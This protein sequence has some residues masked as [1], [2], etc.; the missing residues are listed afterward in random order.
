MINLRRGSRATPVKLLQRLL[1][2]KGTLTRLA[3]DGIFGPRTHAAVLLFQRRERLAPDGIVGPRT[4]RR[5]G[6]IIDVA[7]RVEPVGQP[8]GTS[9]WSAAAT[10]ILGNM[11]VGPGS[12]RLVG[13]GLDSSPS[14][15]RRFAEELG[16]QMYYPQ[17]WPIRSLAEVMRMKPVWV[18]G[19]GDASGGAWAHAVV[20]SGLWS[21]GSADGS[22]T[23]VQIHDPWPVQIGSV[24]GRFYH[25][26]VHGFDFLSMY[27][28]QPH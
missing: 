13:G 5:L 8:T 19:G 2:K 11:S 18:V 20:L 14:N 6:L 27:L 26:T 12:A 9:C 10:M 25:G 15:I 17:S 4:W 23:L 24:Y 7:H 1:N 28:L 21:D 22:G 3:E 16:W